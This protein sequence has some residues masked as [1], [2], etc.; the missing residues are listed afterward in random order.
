M[1]LE[2]WLDSEDTLEIEQWRADMRLGAT[3]TGRIKVA[4][5]RRPRISN[6]ADVDA[7]A[8]GRPVLGICG[9]YQMLAHQ[10]VDDVVGNAGTAPG[11]GLLPTT[12]VTFGAAKVLDPPRGSWEGHG[13]DTAY[14][15]HHG[16]ALPLGNSEVTDTG[17]PVPQRFLDGWNVG[18][19]WGTM[20]R[21]ALGIDDFV[22][23]ALLAH[24]RV[25]K[26]S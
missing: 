16:S 1:L 4:V 26:I 20:W 8:A 21:G 12:T 11:L 19:V 24:T 14:E 5:V 15:I 9:G 17:S 18:P 25:A 3:S 23:D 13:V 22:I 2:V 10:I 7:F 6:V